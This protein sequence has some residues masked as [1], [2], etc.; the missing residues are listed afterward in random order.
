MAYHRAKCIIIN[1]K[2]GTLFLDEAQ[3]LACVFIYGEQM[4]NIQ[5]RDRQRVLTMLICF[6]DK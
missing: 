1:H 5:R 2:K 4:V 6:L 3:V